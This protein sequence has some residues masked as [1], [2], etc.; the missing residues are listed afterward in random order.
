MRLIDADTAQAG[1]TIVADEQTSGK[2]QRGNNW[3]DIPLQ[4]LLMSI[5]VSPVHALS[6]QFAYNACVTSAIAAVLQNLCESVDVC[7]KWP[8]DV[9]MNDKKAGG[10]L[11]ENVLRG[12]EWVYSIVGFGLNVRQE[13]FAPDLPNATSVYL[14]T[15]KLFDVVEL[16]WQIRAAILE[17]VYSATSV[18]DIMKDYNENLYR[19]SEKQLFT[20]GTSV[21]GATIIQALSNGQLEVQQENGMFTRY[22]HGAISWKW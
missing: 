9:I 16:G 7:I 17:K 14:Q 15:G 19:R 6:D 21:W 20:D 3:N 4:S 12:S 22:T 2:G 5:V 1:L 13:Q 11:I 8:N 10:V 18:S